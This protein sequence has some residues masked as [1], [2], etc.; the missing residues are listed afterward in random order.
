[1]D[2]QRANKGIIINTSD[3]YEFTRGFLPTT[4]YHSPTPEKLS[5]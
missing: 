5:N 1:M 2:R 4:P 3:I